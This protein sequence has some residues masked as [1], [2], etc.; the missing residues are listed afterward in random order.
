M[1]LFR[2][3]G[4][5]AWTG[6]LGFSGH[7]KSLRTS[8]PSRQP[9]QPST[10][11]TPSFWRGPSNSRALSR[12]VELF[13]CVGQERPVQLWWVRTCA[14][15]CFMLVCVCVW[16]CICVVDVYV[17]CVHMHICMCICVC[18]YG[19]LYVCV[20]FMVVWVSLWLRVCLCVCELSQCGITLR[21][22][23]Q[24]QFCRRCLSFWQVE[25]LESVKRAVSTEYY[26]SFDECVAWARNLFQAN[27]N[28][29]IKQLLFNFPP[30]QVSS[31]ASY[32]WS[33]AAFFFSVNF[34]VF[35]KSLCWC[36][37][38]TLTCLHTSSHLTRSAVFFL[39]VKWNCILFS[40]F[41]FCWSW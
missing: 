27:Y 4:E 29:Q 28:N 32:L 25:T 10:S 26:T 16:A 6:V 3:W 35:I 41:A 11:Q 40:F 24:R 33:R 21:M 9:T 8:L 2:E 13:A 7:V 22:F 39:L 14:S 23:E 17:W 34:F 38:F 18:F 30:D 31:V 37:Y 36:S 20:C 1:K 12:Y 5:E 15:V 19:C